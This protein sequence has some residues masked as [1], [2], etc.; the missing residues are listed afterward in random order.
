MYIEHE[1]PSKSVSFAGYVE[2]HW[3]LNKEYRNLLWQALVPATPTADADLTANT[4]ETDST[5]SFQGISHL[6]SMQFLLDY[7]Q[8]E[9]GNDNTKTVL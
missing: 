3:S 8:K 7:L 5:I 1:I 2:R 6:Y 4:W 9:G